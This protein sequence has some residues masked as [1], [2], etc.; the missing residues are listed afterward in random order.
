MHF[1]QWKQRDFITLLGGAAV[2]P[3]AAYAQ[4]PK[5]P[6]VGFLGT[7]TANSPTLSGFRRGLGEA[8]FVEGRHRSA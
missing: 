7:S 2:W 5:M 6:L 3:L 1:H 8:G 4:Q